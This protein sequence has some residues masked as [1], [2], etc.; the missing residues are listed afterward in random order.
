[1]HCLLLLINLWVML[2]FALTSEVD[3]GAENNEPFENGHFIFG[4]L[5]YCSFFI[6]QY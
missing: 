1:M 4:N 5:G 6:A 2:R 3:G